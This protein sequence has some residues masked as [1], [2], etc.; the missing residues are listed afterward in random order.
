MPLLRHCSVLVLPYR[1]NCN[2]TRYTSHTATHQMQTTLAAARLD[3]AHRRERICLATLDFGTMHPNMKHTASVRNSGCQDKMEVLSK[4]VQ[5]RPG[6]STLCM[7]K[8]VQSE[9]CTSMRH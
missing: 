6:C 9:A 4:L 5:P 7:E 2:L 1:N 3:C 8:G